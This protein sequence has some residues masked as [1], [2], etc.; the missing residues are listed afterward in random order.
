MLVEY[1]YLFQT[2]LIQII[3]LLT[4]ANLREW[5]S[6]VIPLLHAQRRVFDYPF[7]CFCEYKKGVMGESNPRPPAPKAGIIPLDQSPNVKRKR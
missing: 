1:I 2:Y 5:Y 3:K 7:T 6:D 4:I